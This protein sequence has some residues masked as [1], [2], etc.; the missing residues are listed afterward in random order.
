MQQAIREIKDAPAI[1]DRHGSRCVLPTII[2]MHC[3]DLGSCCSCKG[4]QITSPSPYIT[5]RK[6]AWI[7][8]QTGSTASLLVEFVPRHCLDRLLNMASEEIPFRVVASSA[9]R[10]W[11]ELNWVLCR[12]WTASRP[13]VEDS[14]YFTPV[15][16]IRKES[17]PIPP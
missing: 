12:T 2:A 16:T 3:W 13:M 5:Q 10:L 4:S 8:G 15:A 11:I 17:L 14:C 1:S 7:Q 9:P 6:N